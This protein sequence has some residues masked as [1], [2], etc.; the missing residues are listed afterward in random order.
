[1]HLIGLCLPV[2]DLVKRYVRLKHTVI[3]YSPLKRG[4]VFGVYTSART[5]TPFVFIQ[6]KEKE[7]WAW[8]KRL[9]MRAS[10]QEIEGSPLLWILL[11]IFLQSNDSNS[12]W[13][14][15]EGEKER[16]RGGKATKMTERGGGVVREGSAGEVEMAEWKGV[17]KGGG[18]G[19]EERGR[20]GGVGLSVCGVNE[21]SA[22]LT[23]I[24]MCTGDAGV[25]R[26]AR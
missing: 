25:T 9:K 11:T 5:A 14:D 22:R 19:E 4:F 24:K 20:W 6:Q 1:M 7:K 3:K 21:R 17:E 26:L 18:V 12:I 16:E 8:K 23:N 13:D 10:E 15:R 2:C